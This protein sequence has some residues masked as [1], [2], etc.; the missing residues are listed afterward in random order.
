[1]PTE[2]IAKIPPMLFRINIL[3]SSPG[4]KKANPDPKRSPKTIYLERELIYFQVP[5]R[6]GNLPTGFWSPRFFSPT[7]TSLS[8]WGFTHNLPIKRALNIA[9]RKVK[10]I[11]R[12][13]YLIPK[14]PQDRTITMGLR[15]GVA[16]RK[17]KTAFLL[18]WGC[19]S[20]ALTIGI[21]PQE[22]MGKTAARRKEWKMFLGHSLNLIRP[23]RL[24][25]KQPRIKMGM[26]VA[27]WKKMSSG[28]WRTIPDRL[29]P[30]SKVKKGQERHAA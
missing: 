19:S 5:R 16:M 15:M 14:T 20:I 9:R 18:I 30:W 11:R 3:R 1:M 10:A 26:A 7:G 22:Q 12:R 27:V 17:A 23:I 25:I 6:S 24:A 13:A 8:C 21:T 4:R 2:A 29:Y 28:N